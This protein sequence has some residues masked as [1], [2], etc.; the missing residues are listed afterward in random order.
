MFVDINLP[1]PPEPRGSVEEQ[2]K[3]LRNY[4]FQI[5]LLLNKKGG[6]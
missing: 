5:I 4:I 2:I 1:L 6:K 3:Q